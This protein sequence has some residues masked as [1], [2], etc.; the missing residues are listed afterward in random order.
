[1]AYL[2][3]PHCIPQ[4]ALL[5]AFCRENPLADPPPALPNPWPPSYQNAMSWKGQDL[6]ESYVLAMSNEEQSEI[7]LACAAYAGKF[8]SVNVLLPMKINTN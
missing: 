7:K 8:D 6:K 4:Q 1:M 2:E 3:Y 5:S